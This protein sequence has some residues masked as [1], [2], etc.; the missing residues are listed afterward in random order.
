MST[1]SYNLNKA[2]WNASL[3][4][5]VRDI[6]FA[7]LPLSARRPTEEAN[8][9]WFTGPPESRAAFDKVC[10]K[11]FSHAL[12][13]IGPANYPLNER[14]TDAL[15]ASFASEL[16]SSDEQKN[17]QTAL[18]LLL[19]LDQIPRNIFRT[20]EALPLV[21]KCYD[22][23]ALSLARHIQS[24]KPRPDLHPSIRFSTPYR[25][26]FY[27]PFMHSEDVEDH[28]LFDRIAEEC[29]EEM[30]ANNEDEGVKQVE[31]FRSFEK[32]HRDIIDGWGRYP[33]RNKAVG[34]ETTKEEKDWLKSGGSTFG[35]D[36]S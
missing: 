19:L 16:Q 29:T 34:R 14:S 20:P 7:T 27:L 5:K 15:T 32:M 3:Y 17:S 21:Y 18:S 6:W 25:M 2:I 9:R 31:N 10:V 12:E 35:V 30:K 11:E 28:N 33:H 23:I 36:S 4:Q 8:Q 22:P 24:M 13:S 26:W 1:L